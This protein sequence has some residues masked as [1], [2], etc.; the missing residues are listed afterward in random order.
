MEALLEDVARCVPAQ[1]AYVEISDNKTY[2]A[3][4]Y[5]AED[6]RKRVAVFIDGGLIPRD[7]E[8][9][10]DVLKDIEP[11]SEQPT[12]REIIEELIED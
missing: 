12:L 4:E 2:V 6:I 11:F 7:S 10:F 1:S 5:D 3:E 9:A 8:I